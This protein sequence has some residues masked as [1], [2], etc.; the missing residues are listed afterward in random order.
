MLCS[1]V[2][3]WVEKTF[4]FFATSLL[5]STI[6]LGSDDGFSR[7]PIFPLP[8]PFLFYFL[9]LSVIWM[10]S[11]TSVSFT[12]SRSAAKPDEE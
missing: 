2:K 10:F 1:Q 4:L 5:R 11:L 12:C 9:F 8:F 6:S 7:F 3:K